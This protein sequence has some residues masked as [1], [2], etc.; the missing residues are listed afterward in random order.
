MVRH[1]SC[2]VCLSCKANTT[3]L[4]LGPSVKGVGNVARAAKGIATLGFNTGA[5]AAVFLE[6]VV[7][8]VSTLLL[9]EV[10]AFFLETVPLLVS[11]L[12]APTS[13]DTMLLVLGKTG[14]VAG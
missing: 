1:S 2:L 10:L 3:R 9:E 14:R 12:F 7:E 8:L 13:L 11:V 6:V 4:K 5:G